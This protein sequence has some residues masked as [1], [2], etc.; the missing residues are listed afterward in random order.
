[1]E[2][3]IINIA[4]TLS[5]AIEATGQKTFLI[6]GTLLHFV[7]D[8]RLSTDEDLDIGVIGDAN[9]AMCGL[10][11]MFQPC[12]MVVDDVTREPYQACF[13]NERL[14]A[15]LDVF[16]WK[17]RNGMYYH[18]YDNQHVFPKNGVLP[19]YTFKG[20][21]AVC[22]D[23][24]PNIIQTYQEDLRYGRSMTNYGTWAKLVPGIETEG[25]TLPLPFNYGT[26]LD[27]WYPDWTM[28]RPQFG[29]SVA[30]DIFTVKTCKGI[31]WE[32]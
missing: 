5:A 6:F 11:S 26:C 12:H 9:Q 19:E 1:M 22:F 10:S 3:N 2:Q 23:V 30:A 13:K 14:C 28:K 7:R 24:K 21:P 27:Y 16:F 17:K 4:S 8:R 25:V 32:R 15:C 31:R 20:V 18:C 29:V